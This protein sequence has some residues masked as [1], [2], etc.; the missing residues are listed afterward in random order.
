MNHR[1]ALMHGNLHVVPGF[2]TYVQEAETLDETR[3][4]E[5]FTSTSSSWEE[6][7]T[8]MQ[9]LAETLEP[10]SKV[11]YF[12]RHAEGEHNA[13]K[14]RLGADAWFHGVAQSEQY[15]D[16]PLTEKGQL[17][18]KD[19]AEKIEI[20][21]QHGM[22]LEKIIV[23]PLTRTLQTATTVFNSQINKIPFIAQELCRE[24]LG[25]HTCDKRSAITT[26]SKQFP[27]VDF[28]NIVDNEDMLW[29]PE[30]RESLDDIQMR[31]VTFL[32]NIFN[33]V[34]EQFLA[35]VSHVGFITAC[36]RVLEQPEYRVN[37]CEILPIVMTMYNNHQA[38]EEAPLSQVNPVQ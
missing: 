20:A 6:F 12:L 34:S 35:V 31:A 38:E 10:R 2:F 14:V 33:N 7:M 3:L 29:H 4:F 24:T 1:V 19:A 36:L 26:L 16:A 30:V 37:N 8:A 11:I 5:H 21:L 13:A 27:Q 18:A 9:K 25:I 28:N 32:E 15:L 23:S 22:P 17:A